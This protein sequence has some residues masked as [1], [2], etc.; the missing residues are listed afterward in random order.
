MRDLWSAGSLPLSA[1]CVT[2]GARASG[3]RPTSVRIPTRH[4]CRMCVSR[5]YPYRSRGWAEDR[6]P[7]VTEAHERG[8]GPTRR[9]QPRCHT[10]PVSTREQVAAPV[11]RPPDLPDLV[12][13][14]R[15]DLVAAGEAEGIEV[16][17][18]LAA[19]RRLAGARFLDAA[20][21]GA[22]L[23]GTDF[24]AARFI[25]NRFSGVSCAALEA[26]GSLWRSTELLRCRIGALGLDGAR[27]QSV[28]LEGCKIGH[29]NLHS[30]TV[31]DLLL[32]DC[33]IDAL[34]F[35]AA[36]L[37]RVRLGGCAVGTLT[38][39]A[40]GLTDVDLRGAQIERLIGL[41]ALAGAAITEAQWFDLAPAIADRLGILVSEDDPVR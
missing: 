20:W 10:G 27:L 9:L 26:P 4:A 23:E 3:E 35:S 16:T 11:L 15:A 37:R 22:D 29:L 2:L 41:D 17:G 1:R 21:T 31:E 36:S 19:G 6:S 38:L 32:Q 40:A 33:R 34:D 12:P 28:R 13:A 8:P 25:G 18:G 14:Q 7:S 5:R 24:A 30:A 39:S